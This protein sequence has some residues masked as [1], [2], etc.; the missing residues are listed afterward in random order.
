NSDWRSVTEQSGIFAGAGGFDITVG[1]HTQLDGAVIAST[2]DSSLN[3]LDTGTLGWRDIENH[4]E[5]SV[6]HVGAGISTGGTLLDQFKGNMANGVLAGLNGSDSADSTTKAAV[7]EGTIVIRDKESQQQSVAELSRDVENANPGLEQIFDREKEQNRLKAAQLIAEIGSQALDIARTEGQIAA[8]KAANEKVASATQSD[9]DKALADLKKQDPTKQYSEADISRQVYDNFYNQAFAES[10]LG[11]GGKVQQAIQAATAAIQG[12]AGGNIAQAVSG[13]AAPYLAEQIHILTDGNP[14]AKAMAHAVVGAV[15]SYASGNSA[16]A[17]AAGAVSGELMAQLVMKELYPGK[18]VSELTETEKQTVTALG[19]L[20]AGLAGG[21]TG[22]STANA[23]VG[24]QAGKNAAEFNWLN[25][26]QSVAFDKELSECRSSGGDCQAVIDKWKQISDKQSAETDQKLKDNPL[27]AQVVDKELAQGGVDMAER[28]GWIGNLPGVDV[29]TSEEAK[30]YVQQWNGQDLANINVN[31]PEW[32]KFATLV[33]DPENQALA[34][35]LARTGTDLV[36]AAVSFMSRNTASA[37]V[38]AAEVGMKWGQ[39]N[40]KQGMPWED[41][42]GKALPADARLPQNFKTFD[43]YDGATKTAVSA[44]SMD[45]Q[46]MAK[47]A[48]PNQVYN[49]IK[50]NI[51]AAANF[52][53]YTLSNTP[54]TPGMVSNKEIQLAVPASTTK[55]QWIEINRA[56][57]YGK[58]QGVAVKVTQVK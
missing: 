58:S 32:T 20:A 27:E 31:S 10:G 43:Y 18:A 6:E 15:A 36:R 56:I 9:R 26:S 19:T 54:L 13:A 21:V 55:T 5:Y 42:V 50:G 29:M 30:A 35:S 45:T 52:K 4:A 16:L 33:S 28:P 11:T 53:G 8:T 23:V 39:G 25:Q 41:Y 24:A 14:E 46:T 40:M 34:V 1:E 22:D 44:K 7:S 17:G 57:E 37:T 51:D 48:N 12:L 3:K 38:S 2:A 47:L 49:S